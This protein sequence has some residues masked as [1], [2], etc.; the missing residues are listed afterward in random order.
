MTRKRKAVKLLLLPAAVVAGAASDCCFA[1]PH[2]CGS[3]PGD[4]CL[5]DGGTKC[6]SSCDVTDFDDGGWQCLC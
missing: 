5:P 2:A 4:K 3:L 1:P 6:G